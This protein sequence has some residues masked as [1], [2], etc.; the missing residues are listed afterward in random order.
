MNGSVRPLTKEEFEQ[1]LLEVYAEVGYYD[2][3]FSRECYEI[4][5]L[6]SRAACGLFAKYNNVP[7]H[8]TDDPFDCNSYLY[9]HR[10]AFVNSN[11]IPSYDGV[12]Y[13]IKPVIVCSL[14]NHFPMESSPGDYV[15]YNGFLKQVRYI[16]YMDG[17]RCIGITDL[18]V[19][20]SENYRIS[21]TDKE[22]TF[23]GAFRDIKSRNQKRDEWVKNVDTTLIDDYLSSITII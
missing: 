14:I 10:I 9:G 20:L 6:V 12:A 21:S 8:I 4:C 7:F 2:A 15:F 11:Y 23:C 3:K 13:L 18:D 19:E 22:R 16:D 17:S 1:Y 5:F